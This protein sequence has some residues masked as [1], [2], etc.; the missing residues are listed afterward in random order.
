MME[1]VN[2]ATYGEHTEKT[3]DDIIKKLGKYRKLDGTESLMDMGS[4]AGKLVIAL[5]ST[6]FFRNIGGVELLSGLYN[7]SLKLI[8]KYGKK[9]GKDTSNIVL[10]NGDMLDEDL[11]KY[12][13]IIANM[14]I[15]KSLTEA[16]IKKVNREAKKDAVIISSI[17]PF[18]DDNLKQTEYFLTEYSWGTSHVNFSIK[19]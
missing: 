11:S 10:S 12:D 18:V 8:E 9:F 2:R 15:N 13:V 5:H 6:G 14:P 4:G 19:Q 1:N 3:L 16:M 17:T 7:D